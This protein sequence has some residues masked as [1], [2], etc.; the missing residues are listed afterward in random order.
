MANRIPYIRRSLPVPSKRV[1]TPTRS[2]NQSAQLGP[3]SKW[4]LPLD[5]PAIAAARPGGTP[6]ERAAAPR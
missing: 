5:G 4:S 2:G 6:L 3:V 1:P